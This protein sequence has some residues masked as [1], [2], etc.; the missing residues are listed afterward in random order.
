MSSDGG[1]DAPAVAGKMTLTKAELLGRLDRIIGVVEAIGRL[2]RLENGPE[3]MYVYK[4]RKDGSGTALRADLRLSV[5]FG[6]KG[7]V[8][9]AEGGL[10]LELAAQ[11][12]KTDGG[13]AKFGWGNDETIIRTKLGM[14]DVIN[15]LLA[16][17]QVRHLGGEVPD[18]IR[19]KSHKEATHSVELFHK[20]GKDTT[21]ISLE[22]KDGGSYLRLSRSKELT[23]SVSLSLAEEV[24][25]ETYL[26]MAL[27]AFLRVGMR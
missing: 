9:E 8:S 7:F 4:P 20:F 2:Q 15:L 24:Q 21:I 3:P 16:F 25:L 10:Y 18:A 17:R 14:P 23:R 11:E 6:D 5:T 27:E 26:Q 12:G 19:P 22:F 1:A 13:F